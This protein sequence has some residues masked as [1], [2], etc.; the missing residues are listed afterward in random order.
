MFNISAVSPFTKDAAHLS[1]FDLCMCL[2][3]NFSLRNMQRRK[4]IQTK[5]WH[6]KTCQCVQQIPVNDLFMLLMT[7]LPH[8]QTNCT[9][10]NVALWDT[11]INKRLTLQTQRADPAM[12]LFILL[13]VWNTLHFYKWCSQ[14][15]AESV[16]HSKPSAS[17]VM[18][19]I[20]YLDNEQESL[21]QQV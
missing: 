16:W 12:C 18:L 4:K 2:S 7:F 11:F 17:G 14:P 10:S 8:K 6:L 13:F 19:D 21:E 15:L 5:P 20:K 3:W 9:S 1:F